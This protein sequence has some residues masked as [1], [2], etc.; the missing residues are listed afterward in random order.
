LDAQSDGV[1][2]SAANETSADE[3][4]ESPGTRESS[5]PRAFWRSLMELVGSTVHPNSADIADTATVDAT[6]Q[7]RREQQTSRSRGRCETRM[8]RTS[9]G[10]IGK[11]ACE[12][13]ELL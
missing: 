3:R 4:S 8:R 9:S 6:E 1:V 2:V 7:S 10:R 11:S 12:A 13:V 5:S